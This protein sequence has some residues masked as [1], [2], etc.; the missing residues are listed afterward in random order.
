MHPER[1]WRKKRF[2]PLTFN[3]YPLPPSHL[4][5]CVN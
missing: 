2:V 4:H 5:R 3:A 1:G